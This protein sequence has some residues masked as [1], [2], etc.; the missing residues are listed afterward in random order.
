MTRRRAATLA[1]AAY[2]L[3]MLVSCGPSSPDTPD[4]AASAVAAPPPAAVAAAAAL[5]PPPV[6]I[7]GPNRVTLYDTIEFALAWNPALLPIA[8][9]SGRVRVDAFDADNDGRF[10]RV[11]AIFRHEEGARW[12]VPAF[13]MKEQPEGPW[14]WRVRFAPRKTGK[15]RCT[16][17]VACSLP[18]GPTSP[19]AS[20]KQGS[21][22]C[23]FYSDSDAFGSRFAGGTTGFD[24]VDNATAVGPLVKAM[25]GEN[26]NYFH[27]L[28]PGGERQWM[29]GYAV[30]RPWVV[31]DDPEKLFPD[32][33]LDRESELLEPMRQY[34]ANILYQWM[35]PWELLLVHR[36]RAELWPV[37][38]KDG[39]QIDG[40]FR[41]HPL[42]KDA[43]WAS[44]AW[45]DQGRAL[46][47][48]RIMKQLERYD[49]RLGSPIYLMLAVLPHNCFQMNAHPWSGLQSSWSVEDDW[50]FN[51]P[52]KV[53]G[54]SGFA[55]GMSAYDFF[56]ASPA[57]PKS[58]ARRQLWE[59]QTN[60]FRYVI[61][62]WGASKS[63][64]A[65]VLMDELDAVGDKEGSRLGHT[66]WWGHAECSD[67]HDTALRFFRGQ[68]T[69]ERDG[70]AVPYGGDPY[71]HLITSSAMVY[72]A[73]TPQEDNGTWLGGRE[74][75]DFATYHSYP[76][77]VSKGMWKERDGQ[78]AFVPLSTAFYPG[79]VYATSNAWPSYIG[80]GSSTWR[81][82]AQ[83]LRDWAMAVGVG[84]PKMITE[85]GYL[86]RYDPRHS[87][88]RYGAKY[89]TVF[90]YQVWSAIMNGHASTPADWCDG[91]EF[92]EMRWRDREG[93]FSRD[94]YPVNLYL[95]L[96]S[97]RAFLKE[98]D[99]TALTPAWAQD[100]IRVELLAPDGT[101]LPRARGDCWA[102][103]SPSAVAGWA[104]V[105]DKRET[106]LRLRVRGLR[107]DRPARARFFNTWTGEYIG[108]PV[109]PAAG[110]NGEERV[111]PLSPAMQACTGRATGEVQDDLK[112]V[113][114]IIRIAGQP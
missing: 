81:L 12:V 94:R 42:P 16:L 70:R 95:E 76:V 44:Y 93:S 27:R 37:V 57:F 53:N 55:A 48:D 96:K 40:Q 6:T 67:W 24:C 19:L 54:F 11:D 36:K 87:P 22:R 33:W 80:Y 113:A 65:W 101:V 85:S 63:L 79:G 58:D 112:D 5:A 10:V 15:W 61:A 90:H 78:M 1:A 7:S 99:L 28:G 72:D 18:R 21:W 2:A 49:Q 71:E 97:A 38:D 60:F 23:E 92:G 39:R 110:K 14:L 9:V 106:G 102:L 75:V 74:Q 4:A 62:R 31:P 84:R 51:T 59:W 105:M 86:Q 50:G 111:F 100:K 103:V 114:F 17:H 45:Y 109:P 43:D 47:M 68:L 108:E 69:Y 77:H 46:A 41:E 13:A 29:F 64:G 88:N 25:A 26:P 82:A 35:A 32:E 91:K 73:A 8:A 20:M 34:G 30:A 3:W 56:K 52:E 98:I 89:P 104:F 107:R 66:G 83:R